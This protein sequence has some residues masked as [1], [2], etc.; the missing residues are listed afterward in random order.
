MIKS[1][2]VAKAENN[3]IGKENDLIWHL[4]A[5]QKYFRKTT[6]GHYVIM[7]RKTYQ[8]LAKPLPGRVNIIITRNTEFKAEGA[9]VFD[10]F[11]K[12]LE[13]AES[14]NQQEVFILGGGEIYKKSLPLM[15]K[16][17]IT[18]INESFEGDT[19]FP[20]IDTTG[21]QEESRHHHPAD[22]ENPYDFDFVIYSRK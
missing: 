12:A 11:E 3:V 18:E 16:L 13:F 6:Y 5:D 15:D 4:P 10:Q 17:Y 20:E 9:V 2:I 14:Q 22:D 8:S 21:W 1:I 19:Y 7:G